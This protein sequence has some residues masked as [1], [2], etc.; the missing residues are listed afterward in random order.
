MKEK[1]KTKGT[2]RAPNLG[3]WVDSDPPIDTG[4][5]SPSLCRN[6]QM[7]LFGKAECGDR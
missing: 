6:D 2:L 3:D 7:M 4:D 1:K 5:L